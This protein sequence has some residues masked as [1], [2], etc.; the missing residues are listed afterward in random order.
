MGGDSAEPAEV[1]TYVGPVEPR[2]NHDTAGGEGWGD[3]VFAGYAGA[4][5]NFAQIATGLLLNAK[6][7]Q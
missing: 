4:R 2:Q 3:Y 6:A 1:S 5:T 7:G